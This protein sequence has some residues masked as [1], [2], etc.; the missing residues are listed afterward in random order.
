[1]QKVDYKLKQMIL[2]KRL[3]NVLQKQI[4]AENKHLSNAEV[5]EKMKEKILELYLNYVFLGNNVY[6]V[7]AASKTYFAQSKKD[8]VDGKVTFNPNG[9]TRFTYSGTNYTSTTAITICQIP[10]VYNGATQDSTC[11]ASI[12]MPTI[13]APSGFTPLGW[14]DAANNYTV[15]YT[16]GQT[17]V[18]LTSGSTWLAQSKKDGKTITITF[19]KNGNTSQTPKNGTASTANTITQSC[20]IAAVYNGATQD[21]TCSITSPTI[22]PASGFTVIG[23]STASGT[24]TSGWKVKKMEK[25]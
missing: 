11:S 10:A 12:T 8:A 9:N 23:Y 14:S 24:H 6:G 15:T 4:K 13:T 22:T 19:N 2:A 20:N 5:K 3:N 16:S 21:S 25:Q 17:N 1:M 7:E 18:T